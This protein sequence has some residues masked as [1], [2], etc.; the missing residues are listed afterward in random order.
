MWKQ[1]EEWKEKHVNAWWG[2]SDRLASWVE[3]Y[4]PHTFL[5]MHMYIK[6]DS[7]YQESFKKLP[8]YTIDILVFD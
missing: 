7:V 8:D 4:R 1:D 2:W 6:K 3:V 5:K